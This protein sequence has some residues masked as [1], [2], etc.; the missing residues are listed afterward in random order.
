MIYLI[1]ILGI[2][3]M[4]IHIIH[5]L[6]KLYQFYHSQEKEKEKRKYI[7]EIIVEELVAWQTNNEHF[8][9]TFVCEQMHDYVYS[10][11]CME[12]FVII[13]NNNIFPFGT[14]IKQITF[15]FETKFQKITLSDN[16]KRLYRVIRG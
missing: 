16:Q 10:A 7:E 15:P 9:G 12:I 8:S 3:F 11:Y 13:D 6:A 4:L 5:F 1:I 2:L 14:I